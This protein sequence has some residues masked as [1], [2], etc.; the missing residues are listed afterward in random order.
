MTEEIAIQ[1]N[2]L[3]TTLPYIAE[4]YKI[5]FELFI[6]KHIVDDWRSVIHFSTGGNY[7]K[8]G[9][10][11]PGLYIY[12]DKKLYMFSALSGDPNYMYLLPAALWEGAWI[13]VEISQTLVGKKVG[14]QE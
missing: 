3:L 7:G 13:P 5:S 11:I 12:A 4:E 9:D 8:Y 14:K 6:T 2:N 10:R 1:R